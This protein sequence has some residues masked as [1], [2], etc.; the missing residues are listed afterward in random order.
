MARHKILLLVACLG[1]LGLA[2]TLSSA[3]HAATYVF[4]FDTDAS[5]NQLDVNDLGL[6]VGDW[7]NAGSNED[8]TVS[9]QWLLDFGVSIDGYDKP[10]NGEIPS[11]LSQ[12]QSRDLVLFNTDPNYYSEDSKARKRNDEFK[13]GGRFD[14][15]LLTGHDDLTGQ[16]FLVAKDDN[17][18][19][20]VN[21][22]N[23]L[24]L[25]E[26]NKNYK[27]DDNANGGL[28]SFSFEEM[29]D[30]TSIDLLDIDDF[31]ARGKHIVFAA[32]GENDEE[33]ATWKF[34]EA[35]IND[36]TAEQLS[37]KTGNNSLYRFNFDSAGVKRLDVLYPGSGAIA[38]LRW[39]QNQAPP[40]I[41]EPTAV[42]GLLVVAGLGVRLKRSQSV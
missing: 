18:D 24:I 16:T 11:D 7:Q 2:Q 14:K 13:S 26:N 12:L 5:G 37:E 34:D 1:S 17:S 27:P 4:D 6:N 29:I 40:T 15:D 31:G 23:V 25:Q 20:P 38:A 41:P 39:E 33:I 30:L 21:L 28:I 42:L 8:Y 35:A 22:G 32:Y 3:A 10:N 36:G 9:D 19:T